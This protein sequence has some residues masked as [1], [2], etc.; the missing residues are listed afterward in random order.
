MNMIT[1]LQRVQKIN[2]MIKSARTGSP[3]EFADELGI[4][5][6]HFYRYIDELHE[7]GVPVQYSRARRTYYYENN[8]ELSL[9]Y[10]LKIISDKGAKEIIG[11][12]EKI[13]S[14]LFYESGRPLLC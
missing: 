6:S 14:L 9:S 2:R 12:A 7:M 8:T 3:K 11:G 1:Q 5:E 4:S 13:P 10:S